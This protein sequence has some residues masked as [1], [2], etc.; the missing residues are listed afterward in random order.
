ME[1]VIPIALSYKIIKN[2]EPV[3][4][5]K[6]KTLD[7]SLYKEKS[8]AMKK[9]EI[10]KIVKREDPMDIVK[11]E[12]R[13]TLEAEIEVKKKAILEKARLDLQKEKEIVLQDAYE[14]GY[15]AGFQK[16]RE[17]AIEKSRS[18]K[19][20][21]L[22]YLAEAEQNAK[23]Y[24]NE[25]EERIVRLAAKIAEKIILKNL[26]EDKDDL[27]LLARP[28]L[29]EYGKV[30]NVIISCHPTKVKKNEKLCSGN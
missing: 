17:E 3:E 24:L 29:Q 12:I 25:N 30:Q 22:A 27:M 11:R 15:Q 9:E 1:E 21:A 19:E 18:I 16:G 26:E 4:V 7:V 23:Q 8:E 28:V 6:L 13:K 20:D 5:R 2:S 10:A 14:A